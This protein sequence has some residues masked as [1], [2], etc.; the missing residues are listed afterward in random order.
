MKLAVNYSP[1]SSCLF[2]EGRIDLDLF[3]CPDWPELV[4]AALEEHSTYVHFSLGTCSPRLAQMD[5]SR[6]VHFMDLTGTQNVNLHL[7]TE[8]GLDYHDADRVKRSLQ[9]VADDISSLVARFGP[10]RVIVENTPLTLAGRDH[11]RPIVDPQAISALIAQTG[12]RLLLDVS[13]ASITCATLGMDPRQYILGLPVQRLAEVHITGLAVEDGQ[14]TDHRAM[15]EEDWPLVEWVF[16]Q[17]GSG[18]WAAPGILA[19]EYSGFG[20]VFEPFSDPSVLQT[21]V[22]RLYDMV[23]RLNARLINH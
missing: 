5:W 2:E 18:A 13:H 17:I 4:D 11:L 1:Q 14:L 8:P 22:P 15:R 21:Q 23:Q 9:Q 16:E 20:K 19:F 6:V 12:C 3:K 7:V 10:E